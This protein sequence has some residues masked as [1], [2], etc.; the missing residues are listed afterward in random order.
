MKALVIYTSQTGFTKKYAGWLA[1]ELGAEAVDVNDVK[2]SPDSRFADYDTIV[3]GG[4][5]NAGKIVRADW[6]LNKAPLWKWKK[7][8][9]FCVGA[10]KAEDQNM[11]NALNKALDSEQKKYIGIFYLPGGI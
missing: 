2:K 8:A 6:F 7:L 3:Y 4:W 5:A 10:A 9:V 11:K 1:E